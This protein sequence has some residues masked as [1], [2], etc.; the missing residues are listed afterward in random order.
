MFGSGD[1]ARREPGRCHTVPRAPSIW[2]LDTPELVLPDLETGVERSGSR[3]R[4]PA[5]PPAGRR[6][7]GWRSRPRQPARWAPG[8]DADIDDGAI[9]LDANGS[10][11]EGRGSSWDGR[12]APTEDGRTAAGSKGV[13]QPGARVGTRAPLGHPPSEV[14]RQPSKAGHQAAPAGSGPAWGAGREPQAATRRVCAGG[15]RSARST[16]RPA[17]RRLNE[18]FPIA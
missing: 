8:D 9:G 3:V 17:A 11:A 6:Q 18:S 7:A 13:Q 16:G 15:A 5:S 2:R 14:E 4:R 12:R 10:L 1:R